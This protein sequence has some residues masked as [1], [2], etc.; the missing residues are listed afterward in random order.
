MQEAICQEQRS[1]R[2]KLSAPRA[3]PEP[4]PHPSR[5]TAASGS[6]GSSAHLRKPRRTMVG[7]MHPTSR[8]PAALQSPGKEGNLSETRGR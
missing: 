8:S 1:L 4:L 5:P 3:I 6:D 2:E 7:A